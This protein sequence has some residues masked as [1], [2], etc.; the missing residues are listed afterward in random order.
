[1]PDALSWKFAHEGNPQDCNFRN[2][3]LPTTNY[4]SGSAVAHG[5]DPQDRA[6]SPTTNYQLPITNNVEFAFRT[7]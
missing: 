3:Q 6:A 7:P 4:P 1:M 5:G 2:A